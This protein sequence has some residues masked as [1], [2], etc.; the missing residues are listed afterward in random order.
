MNDLNQPGA[1]PGAGNRLPP[2]LTSFVGRDREVRELAETL[3]RSRLVTLTGSGGCGKTRLALRATADLLGR[4]VDGVWWVDLSPVSSPDLVPY[5]VARALGFREEPDRALVD[6]LS[7]QVAGLDALLILDNCEQV[8]DEC[9]ELIDSL[10]GGAPDLHVMA[11]SREPIGIPGE[12]IWRVPSLD[13]ES[14]TRL[15]IERAAQVRPGFSPD[16]AELE[17]IAQICRRLDG[18]PL[19]IELAAAR[20]RMM[21]PTRIAAGLDDRFRLLTGGGRTVMP[22]QQT[23][24]TSVAWSYDLLEHHEQAVLRRLSVF[25]GGFTLES[26]EAV[27]AGDSIDPY[28]VLELLS[29]LV[30]KSVVQVDLGE[31][32]GRYRLLET[33]RLYAQ[34][35]LLESGEIDSTRN[36]H[37]MF[38][39]SLAERAEPELAASDNAAWLTRLEQ[40]HDNLRAALGWADATGAH[41]TLLRLVTA[42]A[43]FWELRGHLGEGCRWFARA[44][45]RDEGPSAV[46]ARALW[47]AAHAAVYNDDYE[48]AAR[49]APEALAMGREVGDEWAMA[50]ALNTLGWLQLWFEPEPA[51]IALAQSIEL[52]RQIGDNWVVA[53]GWKMMTVTWLIQEDHA[54]WADA[55]QELL[56]VSEGLGNKYFIAWYHCCVGWMAARRGEFGAARK[57]LETSLELCHEVGEPATGGVAVSMLGEIEAATGNYDA[58][59][60]RLDAFLQ[61]AA[62]TGGTSGVP[63]ALLVQATLALGRE[64]VAGARQILEP[65]LDEMRRL[66]LPVFLSWG[67]SLFG[68]ALLAIDDRKA[69]VSVLGEAKEAAAPIGNLWLIALADH[70]LGELA[71]RQTDLSRAED[72][73]H[74]ALALRVRGVLFPGVAE[75]L[76]ALASL[77]GDH[78]SYTEAARLFGATSTFRDSMGLARWPAEQAGYDGE[79]ARARQAL[80]EKAFE[81]AWAEGQALTVEDAVAY[82]S[83]ARGERKRPSAGWASLTPTERDVVKLVAQGLTNPQIGEQ[84]FISRATVKTHLAHIFTKLS[85]RSR[86]ELAAEATRRAV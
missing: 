72:L 54:G 1:L 64:D 11:T 15:F 73:H 36:R 38:F 78:E 82:C 30:D 21:H 24:E 6:T 63:I 81:A 14:A 51:R 48:T 84:L 49:Q 45:S 71:R 61:R 3:K 44:L 33:I 10:L 52:G 39:L 9:A 31:A 25:A 79:L 34:Q 74:E 65:F 57:A 32:E 40:E 53:D 4:H 56:D 16:P 69:A 22:R 58:A 20:T 28:A 23:L 13:D 60:A 47:G 50:R 86:A 8:L 19:A 76:E 43:L 26:A 68:A 29:R 77:A 5:S 62:V 18:I 83:R 85:I 41:E 80:G 46:R 55:L 37:S 2:Q 7:E 59:E 70:H 42:L 27:C 35:R 67:L 75:S 12:L 17:V 66:G